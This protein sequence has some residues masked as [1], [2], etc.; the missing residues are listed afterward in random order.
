MEER[1]ETTAAAIRQDLYLRA[2][3]GESRQIR[4]RAR[5]LIKVYERDGWACAR[6]DSVFGLTVDH[7]VPRARGGTNCLDNLQ[8]LCFDCNQRKAD[9]PFFFRARGEVVA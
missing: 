2:D 5:R 8:V 9:S 6:C 7:I 1:A 4:W 3:F